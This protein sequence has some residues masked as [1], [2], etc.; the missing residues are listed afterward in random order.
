MDKWPGW[1]EVIHQIC[2]QP[3]LPLLHGFCR[4][5]KGPCKPAATGEDPEYSNQVSVATIFMADISTP[6]ILPP[7]FPA[8]PEKFVS[9]D[10][11][12]S[13]VFA[14][15]RRGAVRKSKETHNTPKLF[16]L[17]FGTGDKHSILFSTPLYLRGKTPTT[18]PPCQGF[19]GIASFP[20]CPSSC[21]IPDGQ[22]WLRSA[23]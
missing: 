3:Q 20:A 22:T 15:R 14:R 13:S 23:H 8:L 9:G 17:D 1:R 2:S 11:D 12:A 16:H 7:S 5:T 10:N 19:S 6:N 21:R 18:E 4:K